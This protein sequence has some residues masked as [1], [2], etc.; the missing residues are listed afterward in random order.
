[1]THL[2]LLPLKGENLKMQS[3]TESALLD[4]LFLT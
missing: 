3:P 4:A 2:E 1:M